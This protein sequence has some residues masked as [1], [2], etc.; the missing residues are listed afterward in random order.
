MHSALAAAYSSEAM[1]H[2][3]DHQ[4]KLGICLPP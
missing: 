3:G 2:Q 4:A 1:Y